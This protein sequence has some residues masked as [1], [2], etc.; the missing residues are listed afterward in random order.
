MSG[1]ILTFRST[2]PRN[3]GQFAPR[4]G[5]GADQMLVQRNREM[6]R[7]L[8]DAV[9]DFARDSYVRPGASTGR[10]EKA[11]RSSEN[12][13]VSSSATASVSWGVGN[14]R[15]L[16]R[17]EAKYLRQI[18]EGT[19]VH[20]G[21]LIYPRL[22]MNKVQE[23]ARRAWALPNGASWY[24]NRWG[25]QPYPPLVGG[26]VGGG[27]KVRAIST[28]WG[29]QFVK[30]YGRKGYRPIEIKQRIEAH[31]F[32]LGGMRAVNVESQFLGM[33]HAYIE[34]VTEA[35]FGWMG[36]VPRHKTSRYQWK[37]GAGRPS[38]GGY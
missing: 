6:A 27:G 31:D 8:Q 20:V 14:A 28:Y 24:T 5:A 18:E 21:H 29:K 38:L 4:G 11:L 13:Y 3:N 23:S 2:I 9:A 12:A 10:L 15:W 25:H 22:N 7:E 1:G 34:E 19:D 36:N 26:E 17:S 33:A 37:Q 16:D 35:A 30:R 32:F